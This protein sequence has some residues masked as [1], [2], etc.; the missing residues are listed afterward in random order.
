MMHGVRVSC[1][2]WCEGSVVRHGKGS[3][4]KH[5]VTGEAL[6][7]GSVVMHGVTRDAW[8]EGQL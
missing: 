3:V 4:V 1:E 2:A 5:G 8:C 6:C 7:E